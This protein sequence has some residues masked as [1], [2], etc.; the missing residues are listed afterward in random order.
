MNKKTFLVILMI[1][2]SFHL[3]ADIDKIDPVFTSY[4]AD[5]IGTEFALIPVLNAKSEFIRSDK[6]ADGII[7]FENIFQK[8]K[9]GENGVIVKGDPATADL[10][11][12]EAIHINDSITTGYADNSEIM[13]MS[14]SSEIKFIELSKPMFQ[15][16][17]SGAYYTRISTMNAY[18]FTGKNIILGFIDN[19]F[20][21][22][23]DCFYENSRTNISKVWNHLNSRISPPSGFYYGEE[24]DSSLYKTYQIEDNTGHGSSILSLLIAQNAVDGLVKD[25]T[26]IGVSCDLSTKAVI[27]GLKYI[28]K[29]AE[30][31]NKPFAVVLPLNH[32]WGTHDGSGLLENVIGEMFANHQMKR[33]ISVPVGNLGN[34]LLHA[35]STITDNDTFKGITESP[36]VLCQSAKDY[37]VNIDITYAI[38]ILIR[39][40]IQDEAGLWR[41]SWIDPQITPIGYLQNGYS[42]IGFADNRKNKNIHIV[43][44]QRGYSLIGIEFSSKNA[45]SQIDCYIAQGG[46]FAD[47]SGYASMIRGDRGKTIA[48]PALSPQVISSASYVSRRRISESLATPDTLFHILNWSG[49]SMSNIIKPD[50]YSPGKYIFAIGMKKWG[51]PVNDTVSAFQGTSYSAAYTGAALVQLL[52]SDTFLNVYE[53]YNQLKDGADVIPDE[54]SRREH[55]T[56]YGFLN[57]YN[58]LKSQTVG[59]SEFKTSSFTI[60]DS[61]IVIYLNSNDFII[62][63]VEKKFSSQKPFVKDKHFAIDKNPILGKNIYVLHIKNKLGNKLT[64]IE[65]I[66]FSSKH[67][68]TPSEFFDITGRRVDERFFKQGVLF[69]ELDGKAKK[70]VKF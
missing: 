9:F 1:L 67:K 35:T 10:F 60:G 52:E 58:S 23:I 28:E 47:V 29:N 21:P 34:M 12:S 30:S 46:Y 64:A 50:L 8:N 41:S 24:L 59:L 15:S 20:S 63:S 40:I 26:V 39:F 49:K 65:S 25:A 69:E 62:E 55:L 6:S 45:E 51:I 54:V 11:L 43:F 5:S 27:D 31:L 57:V 16:A 2:I 7:H 61:M 13:Q 70:L 3:Y 17:D 4:L 53:L 42:Y 38:E 66:D 56:S 18:G 44:Q 48:S 19:G 37:D 22:D 36:F 32:Y 68:T 33:G 14:M